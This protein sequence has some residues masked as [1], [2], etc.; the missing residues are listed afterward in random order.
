MDAVPDPESATKNAWCYG[1]GQSFLVEKIDKNPKLG[2]TKNKI[3]RKGKASKKIVK[4]SL[5]TAGRKKLGFTDGST[6]T[7]SREARSHSRSVC[8]KNMTHKKSTLLQKLK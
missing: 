6:T 4:N 5:E 1:K 8:T 2:K 3:A 7:T